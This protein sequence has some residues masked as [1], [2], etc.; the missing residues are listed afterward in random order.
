MIISINHRENRV[1]RWFFAVGL[2]VA[3]SDAI[4]TAGNTLPSN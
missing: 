4:K 1:S 3:N 2:L